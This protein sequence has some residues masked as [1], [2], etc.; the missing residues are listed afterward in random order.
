MRFPCLHDKKGPSVSVIKKL[1][2]VFYS[3]I[4]SKFYFNS[5]AT[6]V[7]DNPG[8]EQQIDAIAKLIQE[9]LNVI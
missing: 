3:L 6:F 1:L 7:S 4:A 8:I 9:R 2:N 5:H